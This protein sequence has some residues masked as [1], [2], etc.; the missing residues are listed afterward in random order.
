VTETHIAWKIEKFVP[1]NPSMVVVGD[2]IYFVAD[3]G[4]LTCA[5]AKTGTVHFQER[6]TGPISA[7]ILY[8]DGKL[9]LQDEKGKGVVV[10]PGKTLKI[11]ST[12]DLAEKSLASYAVIGDDL[13]IRTESHLWRVGT[14]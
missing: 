2:E 5:D 11:L 13:L 3:N 12:N 4:V 14:K 10:Q 1:H 7:S 8:A 6:C 9:Y